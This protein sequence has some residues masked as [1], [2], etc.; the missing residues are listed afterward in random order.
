MQRLKALVFCEKSLQHSA[1]SSQWTLTDETQA[2][3]SVEDFNA[4]NAK[5]CRGEREEILFAR[6]DAGKMQ[7]L[8]LCCHFA[9]E[10]TTSLRKTMFLCSWTAEMHSA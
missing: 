3:L 6:G 1:V 5:N 8:R 9:S 7:V 2:P 10:M 4:K